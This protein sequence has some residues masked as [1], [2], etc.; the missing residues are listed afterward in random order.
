MGIWKYASF[1]STESMK[2][3]SLM[4]SSTERAVSIV[5]RVWR[6]NRF[7]GERSIT[8]RQPPVDFS[9]RKSRL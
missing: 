9:T 1:K 4:E 6:T 7:R 8:G 3:F 5:N 2:S